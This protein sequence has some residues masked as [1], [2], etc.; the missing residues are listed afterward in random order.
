MAV[1]QSSGFFVGLP[2]RRRD[3]VTLSS[4]HGMAVIPS[5]PSDSESG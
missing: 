4:T 1:S 5:R 3:I 2:R